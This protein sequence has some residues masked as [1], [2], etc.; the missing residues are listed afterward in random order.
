TTWYKVTTL[1]GLYTGYVYGVYVTLVDQ[2]EPPQ[3]NTD[4]AAQLAAFPE[5]YHSALT[6]LHNA[7]PEWI[8]IADHVSM[9]FET[10]V[11]SQYNDVRKMVEL[12]Q[13]IAWRSLQ[14]D[15]YNWD[16]DS[17][18]I[19]D[20]GRWVAAS[21][22]V[23]GYYMD[24]RNFLDE[25]YIYMFMKQGYN[26][27]Y[28]TEA[29]LN[30]VISGTFLANG[31]TPNSQDEVDK[32]YGGSYT[33]VIMAAAEKSGVSPY[34]IAAKIITEQGTTGASALISGTYGSYQGYYNFLNWGASGATQEAVVAN[35]LQKAKDEGWDS[36]A[37]A[38]IGGAIKLADG[39]IN[40][41]QDTY[42]YMNFNLREPDK[43]W[44]QYAGS[45]YDAYVKASNL[46]KAYKGAFDGAPLVFSIPVYTSIPEQRATKAD[47]G[48][49][50]YNN[51]YLTSMQVSGLSPSFNMYT[52]NYTLSVTGDTTVYIELPEGAALAS[53]K[54]NLISK[55]DNSVKITVKSQTGYY[56]SYTLNVASTV[57]CTLTVTV[58]DPPADG[59]TPPVVIPPIEDDPPTYQKG[60]TN[61]DDKINIV[62]LANVQ[63]HLLGIITLSGSNL[64]AADTNSDGK[65]NIVDLA[66][67]QKHLLGIISLI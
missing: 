58:G 53:A 52:Y 9:S 13:G 18:K 46:S 28:Q 43:Y 26:S 3:I 10:A 42:F 63:K 32:L 41:K 36:R 54:A 40:A 65:I 47:K 12:S 16:N 67:V 57:N 51:Y 34:V 4:F 62:D 20:S 6:A 33:K 66:N 22:E 27:S 48:D 59:E 35:G 55:G 39:Y 37:D 38:I 1:D 64:D 45:A 23:I 11:A 61:G 5:S 44:H 25:T 19:L 29:G 60:D 14:K 8:F 30:R 50:R 31:Y 21:R 2:Q 56:D 17:W 15:Q 49:N 7:H 24:P